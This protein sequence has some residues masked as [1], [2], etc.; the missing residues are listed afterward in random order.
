M[1]CP[2]CQIEMT[3]L[4]SHPSKPAFKWLCPQCGHW[5]VRCDEC[6]DSMS[7]LDNFR[8]NCAC[9]HRRMVQC[10]K[11]KGTRLWVS[12][13]TKWECAECGNVIDWFVYQPEDFA[14]LPE[15]TPSLECPQC[16]TAMIPAEPP[17]VISEAPINHWYCPQCDQE[18]VRCRPVDRETVNQFLPKG[19]RTDPEEYPP[20]PP[21]FRRL[22][23]D[24]IAWEDIC[25]GH[26]YGNRIFKGE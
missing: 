16:H 13:P 21:G 11:C 20:I 3:P 25:D 10:P 9:G 2:Q 18:M 1:Q 12:E 22:G 23:V 17:N 24:Q 15:I 14:P 8:F 26:R 6:G 5:E 7:Q 19:F 4:P